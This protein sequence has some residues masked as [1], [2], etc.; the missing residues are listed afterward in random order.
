VGRSER[1]D[2][3]YH[4]EAEISMSSRAPFR[5]ASKEIIVGISLVVAPLFLA[6]ATSGVHHDAEC[7]P[8]RP[9]PSPSD[10][11]LGA[12]EGGTITLVSTE[13]GTRGTFGTDASGTYVSS[14]LP[15]AVHS[16]RTEAPGC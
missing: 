7:H 8:F 11:S 16:F 6:C 4:R 15:P 5:S 13:R 12:P 14:L 3:L 9:L 1:D 10:L 2:N